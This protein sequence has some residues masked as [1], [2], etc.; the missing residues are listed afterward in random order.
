MVTTR[1]DPAFR[2]RAPGHGDS[3]AGLR[4]MLPTAGM[5]ND[6]ALAGSKPY[7]W[8]SGGPVH[9]HEGDLGRAIAVML[10]NRAFRIPASASTPGPARVAN[11]DKD[12][13]SREAFDGNVGLT[14][15]TY[16]RDYPW[17]IPVSI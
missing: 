15:G 12:A 13:Q 8:D 2:H 7:V 14:I 4:R 16:T 17:V 5:Q 11:L 3:Q 6:S 10:R 1:S 9:Q